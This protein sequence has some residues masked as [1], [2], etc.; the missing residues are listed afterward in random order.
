M[1]LVVIQ[2]AFSTLFSSS[3]S[4]FIFLCFS[5]LPLLFFEAGSHVALADSRL[6]FI[7][8]YMNLNS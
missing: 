2:L 4:V 3:P 7:I 8:G 5:S 1:Y 6:N